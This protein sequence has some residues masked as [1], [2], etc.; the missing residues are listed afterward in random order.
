[1]GRDRRAWGAVREGLKD[2]P[3]TLPLL[4]RAGRFII[5]GATTTAATSNPSRRRITSHARNVLPRK[6]PR[7]FR[8]YL[9]CTPSTL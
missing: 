4:M 1:V 9:G 8:A 3:G 6:E 7:S 2:W 5:A